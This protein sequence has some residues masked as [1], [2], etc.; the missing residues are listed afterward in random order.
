M[1]I[2][3]NFTFEFS[4]LFICWI[5]NF[6]DFV[7]ETFA[8]SPFFLLSQSLSSTCKSYRKAAA[9]APEARCYC[10]HS[11]CLL[12]H[13]FANSVF[14]VRRRLHSSSCLSLSFENFI[15]PLS[16]LSNYLK[17]SRF[18]SVLLKILIVSSF[19]YRIIS[20]LLSI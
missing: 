19:R 3:P 6:Y 20:T 10:I 13:Y 5:R 17:N 8:L 12:A 16:P 9:P 18:P 1:H 11:A 4:S 15:L 7:W 14:F 2:F